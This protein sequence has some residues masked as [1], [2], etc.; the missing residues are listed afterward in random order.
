[1]KITRVLFVLLLLAIGLTEVLQGQGLTG[2]ITGLVTDPNGAVVP[3]AK[4]VAKNAG[5]NATSEATTDEN[6]LYRITNLVPG[7]YVVSVEVSGFRRAETAP[8]TLN[9]A[10]ALRQDFTLQLGTVSEVVEVT[11]EAPQVNTD[12]A[13][14]GV[15]ITEI[16][17]LPNI[18]GANGRNPLNLVGLEPGVNLAVGSEGNANGN[19]GGFSVNGQRTQANNYVLDGIDSNDLAINIPDALAQISP[20]ALGEFRVVTGAMKAE[21]GRNG[22]A[23]IEAI[24][25]SGTN[26][27]HFGADEVFRN[28]ALNAT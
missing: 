10:A 7:Q 23:V 21:Y 6:G 15:S 4:V 5:T 20:N 28:T 9:I 12:N 3:N 26:Q 13:Q 27:F 2:S 1:M 25:K 8:Q 11:G 19:V 16:P 22:G 17:N 24:T 18:S 14:L